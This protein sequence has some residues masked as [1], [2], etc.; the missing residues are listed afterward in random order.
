M[1]E[2]IILPDRAIIEVKGVDR[3]SFLQGLISNDI[4]KANNDNLI[5][6]V[7]LNAQGRF[8]YDFFIF[9][10]ND[11]LFL[12]CSSSRR[13]EIFTKLKFYK[14]R[15]QVEIIKNDNY[16]IE[17]N[18]L[19]ITDVENC[20]IFNDPRHNDLGKR[21]YRALEKSISA[22][23]LPLQSQQK[24]NEYH[25]RRICLKIPESEHDLTY[26][27]SI[28]AEFG[29]DNLNAVDYQKGCYIGQELTART[30]YM[31][32]VR[33]KI[34]HIKI[35]DSSNII[36]DTTR[37]SQDFD[38]NNEIS[39]EGKTIGII[40]STVYYNKELHALALIKISEDENLQ[41][42]NDNAATPINYTIHNNKITIIS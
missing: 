36:V 17:Q 39:C 2:K 26:E 19:E 30:H 38:K 37:I 31:G 20:L 9:E 28:I 4:N 34:F 16:E 41:N 13:D 29:F 12:D 5:Y 22:T 10:K 25:Y 6:A 11:S 42:K 14:L 21:I 3:K 24:I 7:M 1:I 23:N 15:A 33:K 35:S 8:L 18:F 27:K 32:Q 40:L